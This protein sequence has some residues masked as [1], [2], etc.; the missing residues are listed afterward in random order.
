MHAITQR[1]QGCLCNARRAGVS[2]VDEAA[3]G[4]GRSA[5][6]LWGGAV[7]ALAASSRAGGLDSKQRCPVRVNECENALP[8]IRRLRDQL[9][10]IRCSYSLPADRYRITQGSTNR[11]RGSLV[12]QQAMFRR[13]AQRASRLGATALRSYATDGAPAAAKGVGARLLRCSRRV[14]DGDGLVASVHDRHLRL[15]AS[16]ELHAPVPGPG[17]RGRGP[18]LRQ[19]E[20]LPG[21]PAG[22]AAHRGAVGRRRRRLPARLRGGAQGDRGP[23]GK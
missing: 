14:P 6:H 23:D 18:V 15:R 2:C 3:N 10:N 13:L 8:K 19:G 4:G 11:N 7:V 1:S 5:S 16:A 17:G 21:Q 12:S 22:R 9:D 20:W